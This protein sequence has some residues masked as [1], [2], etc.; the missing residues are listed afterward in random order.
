MIDD[1]CSGKFGEEWRK[2]A[3][4]NYTGIRLVKK[5]Q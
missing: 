1:H 3:R 4:K 2:D 5:L